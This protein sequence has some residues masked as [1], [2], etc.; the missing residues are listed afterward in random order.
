MVL[1]FDACSL[2]GGPMFTLQSGGGC[3]RCTCVTVST[4]IIGYTI[5]ERPVKATGVACSSGMVLLP[6]VVVPL[7]RLSRRQLPGTGGL[8]EP[9]A[10]RDRICSRC[11]LH[12]VREEKCHMVEGSFGCVGVSDIACVVEASGTIHAPG[13]D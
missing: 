9:G 2:R 12:V 5:A 7:C 6:F 8:S 10:P 13:G 3:L 4:V 1:I 11:S